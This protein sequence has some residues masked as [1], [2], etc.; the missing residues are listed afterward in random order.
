VLPEPYKPKEEGSTLSFEL[1]LFNAVL[2]HCKQEVLGVHACDVDEASLS[3][4]SEGV[5]ELGARG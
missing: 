5:A 3:T 1:A 4:A 2:T